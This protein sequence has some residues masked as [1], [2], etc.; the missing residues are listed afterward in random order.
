M[1]RIPIAKYLV[2]NGANVHLEDGSGRDSCD[3]AH[4]HG[5]K[6]IPEI[7]KCQTNL[8]QKWHSTQASTKVLKDIEDRATQVKPKK[9]K[10]DEIFET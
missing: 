9:R 10:T 6:S 3:Y 1:Q 8:R 7:A 4:I 5:V 2:V